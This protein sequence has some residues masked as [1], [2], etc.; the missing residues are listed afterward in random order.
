MADD[1][2]TRYEPT[3]YSSPCVLHSAVGV[4][5]YFQ[6]LGAC[7]GAVVQNVMPAHHCP[8]ATEP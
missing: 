6:R 7:G 3:H 5:L 8:A 2:T 1:I 4:R